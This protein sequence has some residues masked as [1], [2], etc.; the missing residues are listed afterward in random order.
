M[1]KENKDK[2]LLKNEPRLSITLH[3]EQKEIS[4]LL[5]EY[6]VVFVEGIWGT[7]KTLGAVAAAIKAFRK[8]E[9]NEIVLSRPF[10]PDKG[11]GA[12]PGTLEEK[13]MLETQPMLDNMNAC[14]SKATTD[15]MLKDGDIKV[16]YNGKIKGRTICN[17]IMLIDEGEDLTYRE[18]VEIL[19]RLGKDSKMIFT[20][21]KEQ[22][23][24]S[25]KNDS[26]YYTIQKLRDSGLVGWIELTENH[27]NENINKIIDYLK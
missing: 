20:I 2:R 24:K 21:S 13:L 9:F 15:K 19:T 18:F 26:C 6:D 5:Y 4:A 14:Q 22:I 23:H 8:K 7:G 12:L 16:Q 10:I 17:S 25:I 27:R 11:L 3:P 1:A